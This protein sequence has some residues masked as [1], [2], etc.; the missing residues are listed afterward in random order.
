MSVL[1]VQRHADTKAD[2]HAIVES[3]DGPQSGHQDARA[4]VPAQD[5]TN[6]SS[7]VNNEYVP[8]LP[9]H[10]RCVPRSRRFLQSFV[11]H[12]TF[13][14]E[15]STRNESPL[16]PDAPGD[17]DLVHE[18]TAAS[19]LFTPLTFSAATPKALEQQLRKYADYLEDNPAV[20]IQDLAWTLQERRSTLPYR[21][22]VT[23]PS[24]R[25]CL[26][27]LQAMIEEGLP[28]KDT[29]QSTLARSPKILGIF[30]GQGAQWAR[31]G[32][33]LVE[34]SALC[35]DII[36]DLD[37]GLQ[38]LPVEDRP[39]VSTISLVGP[40]TTLTTICAESSS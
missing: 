32:A 27:K 20:S 5:T 16:D 21:K 6:R 17:D 8:F 37:E 15:T 38:S 9:S 14:T 25:I 18:P 36:A 26:E 1:E 7:A 13:L 19:T 22:V 40:L 3:W 39:T 28:T 30:T 33:R 2:A 23:G 24:A 11:R 4:H 29:R 35:Q 12:Q 31:M 10:L 34:T